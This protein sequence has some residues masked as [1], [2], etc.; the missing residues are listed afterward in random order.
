MPQGV[1]ISLYICLIDFDEV[2]E[3]VILLGAITEFFHDC[4]ATGARADALLEGLEGHVGAATLF[5]A[6]ML[7]GDELAVTVWLN[8]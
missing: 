3:F 8:T 5:I 7:H 2:G 4:G 1:F 6:K